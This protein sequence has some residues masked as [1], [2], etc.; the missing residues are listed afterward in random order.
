VAP[1]YFETLGVRVLQGRTFSDAENRNDGLFIVIDNIVAARLFPNESPVGKQMLSRIRT[2]EPETFEIIGVVQHQRHTALADQGREGVFFPEAL[3]GTGPFGRWAVRTSGDPTAL[4]APIRAEIA[5]LPGPA[6][7]L[8]VEP[9][10]NFVDR[11]SATT[12]FALVLIGIFGGLAAVLAV[13]GL[14]GV[15]STIVRQR[16]AEIGVRMAFGANRGSVFGLVVGQ[17]L[18]LS[19]IGIGLGIG[20]AWLLTGV[21]RTLLVGVTPT[22]PLT[23]AT[24]ALVFLAVS[25]LACAIPAARAARLD[26]LSALREE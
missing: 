17:G 16:T 19:A 2:D 12:R 4:V 26:P 22:D 21:M 1:T 18:S 14:Y 24:I 3:V 11:A 5:R 15:L 23:F 20:A 7:M 6:L 10:T 25:A 9:M 13:I 8:E